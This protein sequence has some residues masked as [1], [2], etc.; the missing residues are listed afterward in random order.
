MAKA[1]GLEMIW[2]LDS[3]PGKPTGATSPT[4]FNGAA[5]RS[6]VAN[7]AVEIGGEGRCRSEWVDLAAKGILNVLR[8]LG[9]LGGEPE[10]LPSTYRVVEGFWRS[11]S[12][13]GF[14]RN[15]VEL[16]CTVTRNQLISTIVDLQGDTIEEIRSD[17]DGV[18]IGLRTLPKINPG[19]W[20]H[21]PVKVVKLLA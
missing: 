19:D 20:T 13:G 15:C 4:S 6:G 1:F 8:S 3:G 18:I 5:M 17:L 16:N 7:I 2:D 11:G 10:G 12:A 14:I 9:M 21:W